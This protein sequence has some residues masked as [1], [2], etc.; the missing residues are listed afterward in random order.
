MGFVRLLGYRA[1]QTYGLQY[2]R[3]TITLSVSF[4]HPA[5]GGELGPHL[6]VRG[7]LVGVVS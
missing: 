4:F 5:A 6:G 3:H 7:H 2:A 1:M